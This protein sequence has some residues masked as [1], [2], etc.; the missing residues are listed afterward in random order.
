MAQARSQAST[1]GVRR[2]TAA[3]APAFQALRLEGFALHP[4]QF[5][6]A[7]EDESGLSLQA[8]G[9]RLAKTFV[10]GGFHDDDLVGV[11]G[12]TRWDTSAVPSR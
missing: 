2:L 6:V 5:R 1:W 9:E 11:G 4:L 12:L 10:V 7:P 3:D 8:V